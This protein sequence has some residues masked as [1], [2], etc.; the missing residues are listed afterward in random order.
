MLRVYGRVDVQ[1]DV[2]I[3]KLEFLQIK[4]PEILNTVPINSYKYGIEGSFI[5]TYCDCEIC[6][7]PIPCQFLY[8]LSLL[9][10]PGPI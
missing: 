5:R 10:K 3:A 7:L 4:R 1:I 6:C 9:A 2:Q 8:T